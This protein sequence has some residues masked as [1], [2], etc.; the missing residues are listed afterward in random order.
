MRL[1]DEPC[2]NATEAANAT[3]EGNWTEWKRGVMILHITKFRESNHLPLFV[4]VFRSIRVERQSYCKDLF[5]KEACGRILKAWM[6]AFL[7][8]P[9]EDN[10]KLI[11][12]QE[13]LLQYLLVQWL[14]L[15][16]YVT[17]ELYIKRRP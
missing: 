5:L 16:S 2:Q 7:S 15:D 9:K 17:M 14:F 8:S 10:L 1:E 12:Y 3:V 4:K 11:F 6:K 13:F